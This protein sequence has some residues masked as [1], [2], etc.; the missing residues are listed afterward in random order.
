MQTHS[1]LVLSRASKGSGSEATSGE[2]STTIAQPQTRDSKPASQRLPQ[3][4]SF[5]IVFARPGSSYSGVIRTTGHRDVEPS[6]KGI[7]LLRTSCFSFPE[8]T[9]FIGDPLV[10]S[11]SSQQL[12]LGLMLSKS[13]LQRGVKSISQG[14]CSQSCSATSSGSRIFKTTRRSN[15]V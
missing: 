6:L 4:V 5:L 11:A 12:V 8:K 9:R 10:T 15:L 3:S 13:V 2:A 14:P 1:Y 7:R